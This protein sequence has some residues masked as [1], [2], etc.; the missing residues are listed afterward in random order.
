MGKIL[1]LNAGP[2]AFERSGSRPVETWAEAALGRVIAEKVC[3]VYFCP[4]PGAQETAAGI[5]GKLGL[6]P[7]ALAGL[8]SVIDP[9]WKGMTQADVSKFESSFAEEPPGPDDINLPFTKDLDALRSEVA[10][11]LDTLTKQHKKEAILIV[12]H[13]M[14]TPVLVLHFLHMANHHYRQVEQEF[15]ALNLFEVRMG[16]PSALYIN[17]TCHLHGLI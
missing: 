4:V 10:S 16:I 11:M 17:D 12:S 1:V 6:A 7:Q 9:A 14:L 3:S 15:G 8:E 2:S 5:A 13:R